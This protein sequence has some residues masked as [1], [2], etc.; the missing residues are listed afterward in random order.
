LEILNLTKKYNVTHRHH[1]LARDHF[2]PAALARED[3][4][5]NDGGCERAGAVDGA[6]G[7]GGRTISEKRHL[8]FAVT[9][10]LRAP[11]P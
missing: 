5:A 6:G 1:D 4:N 9:A 11:T 10:R 2:F 3:D 7:V 8:C